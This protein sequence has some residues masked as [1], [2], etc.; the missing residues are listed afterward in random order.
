[1]S[2]PKETE[3]EAYWRTGISRI[4]PNEIAIR[5][6]PI[7]E[8][9]GNVTFPAMIWLLLRGDFPN[10]GELKLFESA[11]VASVD[12]GPH[13]PS[14]A[15]GRMAISCG[16]PLNG[17]M[18]SAVNALDQVHGG[19][20]EAALELFQSTA[21]RSQ[22]MEMPAAAQSTLQEWTQV[23][24]RHVPGFGH[25]FH[26]IDPRVGPLMNIIEE[27]VHGGFVNGRLLAAA[28]AIESEIN[29]GRSSPIP[30][31]IDGITATIFGELGFAPP[32]ARG[33]FCLS[34]S[35]GILAHAWEQTGRKERNKGPVPRTI[36]YVY[37]GPDIRH[38]ESS[39]G[40]SDDT[41]PF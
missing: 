4:R 22:T 3:S 38:F 10:S 15:I 23:N 8:L 16:L 40:A 28:R 17:A 14:I 1:M 26:K 33:L 21:C 12:H 32:L 11:L 9:I 30:M 27:A 29:I 41:R 18:A 25:R 20:G 34:R 39:A 37:D 24:G 31:N 19:A 36:S 6:Y 7:Q 35:A 2:D 13:A 5:G